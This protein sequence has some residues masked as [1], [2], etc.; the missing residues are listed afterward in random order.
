MS[1]IMKAGKI[2]QTKSGNSKIFS[3]CGGVQKILF[4]KNVPLQK[5]NFCTPP[6]F[7]TCKKGI[8]ALLRVSAPAKKE[9]LH[10]SVFRHLQKRNFCTLPCFDTCKKGI[11]ALFRVSPRHKKL[12]TDRN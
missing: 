6:C 10:S 9:F 11:F 4:C 2:L 7:G 8:F 5:R 12:D 1:P 3:V